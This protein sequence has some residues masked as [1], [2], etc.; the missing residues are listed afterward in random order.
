MSLGSY[1]LAVLVYL[2]FSY[3]V[4]ITPPNWIALILLVIFMM[5]GIFFGVKSIMAKESR[6]AGYLM[7]FGGVFILFL[8]WIWSSYA[9]QALLYNLNI[10]TR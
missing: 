10:G 4:I 2:L 8:P 1:M 7:V 5:L 3:I 6:W 9:F